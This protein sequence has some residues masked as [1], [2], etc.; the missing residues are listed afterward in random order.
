MS[1]TTEQKAL[2]IMF[3]N[4]A[5]KRDISYVLGGFD[6]VIRITE[7]EMKEDIFYKLLKGPKNT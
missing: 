5:S 1:I 2:E 4:D 6:G 7:D 3:P